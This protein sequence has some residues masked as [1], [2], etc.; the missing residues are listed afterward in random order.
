MIHGKNGVHASVGYDLYFLL[1]D[2]RARVFMEH[3]RRLRIMLQVQY[4]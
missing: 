1:C 4:T 2:V 3:D